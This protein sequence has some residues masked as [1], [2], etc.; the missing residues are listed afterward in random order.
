MAHILDYR[1]D[2]LAGRAGTTETKLGPGTNIL[3]GYNGAGKTSLLTILHAALSDSSAGLRR[4][5]FRSA[6]VRIQYGTS[7][8]TR[9]YRKNPSVTTELGDDFDDD[10]ESGQSPWK[11][12]ITPA[13]TQF[14]TPR[15]IAHAYLPISRVAEYGSRPTRYAS[16]QF[17][18]GRVTQETLNELFAGQVND[19]WKQYYLESTR[20]TQRAQERAIGAILSTLFGGDTDSP[21]FSTKA[22]EVDD[23][24]AYRLVQNFFRQRQIESTLNRETFIARYSNNED[25][26]RVVEMISRSTK[27]VGDILR[28]QDDFK[29]IISSLFI[30]NKSLDFDLRGI[31]VAVDDSEIPLSSLSSGERQLVQLL[32]EVMAA[33]SNPVLIDEPELSLHV[34]WQS[35]LLRTARSLNPN[36]QIIAATHSPEIVAEAPDEETIEL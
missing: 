32:L 19:R 27:E 6:R 13:K 17:Q 5:P 15:Q 35:K 8:I 14:Y 21:W 16:R 30:G 2:G 10:I 24:V 33:K 26:R 31:R 1:I 36:C 22:T 7:V 11:S 28:P 9:S 4:V 18:S 12:T 34:D 29:E 23:R 3:W 25:L 20:A